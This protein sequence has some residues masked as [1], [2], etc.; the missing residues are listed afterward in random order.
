M[1]LIIR[2]TILPAPAKYS[3]KEISSHASQA[4]NQADNDTLHS[5]D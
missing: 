5:L 2:C 4:N 1:Q 3:H